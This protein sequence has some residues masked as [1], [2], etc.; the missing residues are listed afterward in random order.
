MMGMF[1]DAVCLGVNELSASRRC[2]IIA[3]EKC[4]GGKN[5]KG[6]WLGLMSHQ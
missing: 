6:I 1:W 2:A 4:I 3:R 5:G